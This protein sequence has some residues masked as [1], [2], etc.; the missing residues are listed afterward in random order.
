MIIIFV[1]IIVFIIII[2]FNKNNIVVFVFFSSIINNSYINKDKYKDRDGFGINDCDYFVFCY[3][4]VFFQFFIYGVF[5][6]GLSF[7]C[8]GE[9]LYLI[10]GNGDWKFV[11]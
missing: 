3:D 7:F 5:W 2:F 4:F 11:F 9:V 8:F 10:F 1:F 6:G